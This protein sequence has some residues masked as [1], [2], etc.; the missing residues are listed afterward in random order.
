MATLKS[1]ARLEN[2][3]PKKGIANTYEK[4]TGS[5]IKLLLSNYLLYRRE[6]NIIA[7]CLYIKSQSKIFTNELLYILRKYL[8]VK[9]LE[10][11]NLNKLAKRNTHI[12]ELDRI[13]KLNELS[14][15]TL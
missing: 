11:L 13:E 2:L 10:D 15:E 1:K 5:L 9:K 7:K 3:A 12:N 6:L 4:T 14:H 8:V